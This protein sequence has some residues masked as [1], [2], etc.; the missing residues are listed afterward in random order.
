MLIDQCWVDFKFRAGKD[1]KLFDASCF[2]PKK[3]GTIEFVEMLDSLPDTEIF[4]SVVRSC[5]KAI[6]EQNLV[7]TKLVCYQDTLMTK[8]EVEVIQ[9]GNLYK[10]SL[11]RLVDVKQ[12][13]KDQDMRSSTF[14][15]LARNLRSIRTFFEYEDF[16]DQRS[17]FFQLDCKSE[18]SLKYTEK[19][20]AFLDF[21]KMTQVFSVPLYFGEICLQFSVLQGTIDSETQKLLIDMKKKYSEDISSFE[22]IAPTAQET[23][24]TVKMK[25]LDI[26]TAKP[27]LT[28]EALSMRVGAPRKMLE[29]KIPR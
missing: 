13:G 29:S 25:I 19:K 12:R 24:Q 17:Y 26:L 1:A 3:L 11:T 6:T 5:S 27:G 16:G 2:I 8:C 7:S 10:T 15:E 21:K 22:I 14:E 4:T 18:T 9:S 20:R 28:F 23:K